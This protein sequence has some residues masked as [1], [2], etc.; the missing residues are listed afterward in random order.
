MNW[1]RSAFRQACVTWW[2]GGWNASAMK[3]SRVL[4]LAAVIG[5]EFDLSLLARLADVDEDALLDLMDAAVAAA[6]LV[7]GDLADRYRFAH[8][9]IQ[10]SL[11]DELCPTRRTA[12]TNAS[13]KH[14]KQ[15]SANRRCGG[16][17][18]ARAS[19][20]RRNPTRRP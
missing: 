5:R 10:H 14:S 20:G 18:R 17:R 8:A 6:V 12:P 1:K 11:Y 7:E 3:H 2:G 13:P 16:T 9:L 4:C 15:V 19:L